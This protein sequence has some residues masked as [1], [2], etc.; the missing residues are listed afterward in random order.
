MR[1]RPAA[2]GRKKRIRGCVVPESP[3]HVGVEIHV[4]GTK[5]ETAAQLERIPAQ[6]MLLVA[7]CPS[8]IPGLRVIAAK[9]VQDVGLP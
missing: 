4:A 2:E 5:D 7:G 6:A 3:A 1:L 9:K 8:A